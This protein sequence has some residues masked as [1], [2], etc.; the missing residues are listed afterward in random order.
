MINISGHLREERKITGYCNQDVPLIVNCCGKQV[1]QTQDYFCNRKNGR[2][3][4]QIIYIHRGSGHFYL[5]NEWI[6][7]SAGNIVLYRPGI[8]QYYSYYAKEKPEIYWIH[9]TGNE[10]ENILKQYDIKNC[11]IGERLYLKLLFQDIITELQLKKIS[12]EDIVL[13]NFYILLCFIHRSFHSISRP[14]DNDFSFDRLLLELNSKYANKWSVASMADYCKL[15]Q[16]S[17]S[18][19]FKDHLIFPPFLSKLQYHRYYLL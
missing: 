13:H 7:L 16:S 4:Y 2:L 9:F 14:L 17:F 19:M 5:N 11:Y 12:Y 3:D 10:C 1:F 6:T 15:S 18:H 8:P